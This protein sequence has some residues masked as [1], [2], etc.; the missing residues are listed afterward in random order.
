MIF[1]SIQAACITVK[2]ENSFNLLPPDKKF[3]KQGRVTVKFGNI[4]RFS[5][6]D[7]YENI[8]KMIYEKIKEL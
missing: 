2:V 6:K 8:T 5:E 7:S 4:I 3:P 1:T